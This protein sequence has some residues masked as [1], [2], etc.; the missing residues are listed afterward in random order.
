MT[1]HP[2][3]GEEKKRVRSQTPGGV[4]EKLD[5]S[6]FLD[7]GFPGLDHHLVHGVFLHPETSDRQAGDS[8]G[9]SDDGNHDQEFHQRHTYFPRSHARS[10]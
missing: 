3:I 5:H 6:P 9:Y 2:P 4:D 10:P 8:G 1:E 7:R